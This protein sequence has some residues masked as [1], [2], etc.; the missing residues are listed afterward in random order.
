LS[1]IQSPVSSEGSARLVEI[2]ITVEI[3]L[4]RGRALSGRIEQQSTL[5]PSSS[6]HSSRPCQL[7]A[8]ALGIRT[9]QTLQRASDLEGG[10]LRLCELRRGRLIQAVSALRSS[11]P[12][13]ART[14]LGTG[15]SSGTAQ[16]RSGSLLRRNRW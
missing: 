6:H 4:S 10:P 8:R 3:A 1:M 9:L 11:S 7:A 16:Q 5:R 13:L 12:T 15:R 14:K 2:S